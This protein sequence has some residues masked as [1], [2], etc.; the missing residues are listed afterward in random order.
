M[1]TQLFSVM[2]KR[3]NYQWIML[4]IA[5]STVSISIPFSNPNLLQEKQQQQQS[6]YAASLT[7]DLKQEIKQSMDS[8]TTMLS[9][10]FTE[11]PLLIETDMILPGIWLE[12]EFWDWPPPP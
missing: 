8:N 4:I 7:S 11:S 2:C 10:F 3:I 9:P 1:Y 5:I 6:A 12:I